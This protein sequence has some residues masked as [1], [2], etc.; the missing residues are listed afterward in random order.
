MSY[1]YFADSSNFSPG[2]AG[3]FPLADAQA[4]HSRG[5]KFLLSWNMSDYSV[6]FSD[7]QPNYNLPSLLAGNHNVYIDQFAI[8][9]AA[10]GQTFLLRPL[11]EFE[12]IAYGAPWNVGR[13]GNNG[14]MTEFINAWRFLYNRVRAK[15]QNAKFVWCP[16]V[17]GV[18][19]ANYPGDAYV[20]YVG[21]DTYSSNAQFYNSYAS[22]PADWQGGYDRSYQFAQFK[23]IIVCEHGSDESGA[24]GGWIRRGYRNALANLPRVKGYVW[25]A[26]DYVTTNPEEQKWR[27][28]SSPKALRAYRDAIASPLFDG[29][30]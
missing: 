28:N 19:S 11:W 13:N 21:W 12:H 2:T 4:I 16:V 22:L 10:W 6:G 5:A 24:K 15:C 27:A 30:V 23:P 14:G 29:S 26:Q 18:Q 25:F 17:T 9:A 8:D 7:P 3:A 1:H 20:D